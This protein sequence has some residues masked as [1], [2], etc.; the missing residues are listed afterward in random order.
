MKL[1][2]FLLIPVI[3]CAAPTSSIGSTVQL[4]EGLIQGSPRDANGILAFKGIPYAQPPVGNLRWRSPSPA[5]PWQGVINATQFGYTC[6][7]SVPNDTVFTPENENC[8]TLNIWTGAMSTTE[9]R[10][11]MVWIYGGGFQFGGTATPVY[12]GEN[13]AKLGVVLVTVNYRT[14]VFGFLAH[15]ELD[16]EGSFS[17]NFGLQDQLF[18]LKWV[19]A[20]IAAFGG[21]PQDITF[22]GES[23]GAMSMG[24]LM[25]SPKAQGLFQKTILESGA[26]WDSEHGNLPNFIEARERGLAYQLSFGATGIDA[27]RALP[28]ADVD[29][30]AYWNSSTDPSVT[31]FGP[32]IDYNVLVDIPARIFDQGRQ[33]Q[34]PMLAGFNSDEEL[35]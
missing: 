11:V 12:N 17:G 27:L 31:A 13:F 3:V 21:D 19:R 10:P 24:L 30:H 34:I 7:S 25:T 4:Q 18:A 26:Y 23:A 32:S 5:T 15:P 33:M 29:S 9:K 1:I 16:L 35:L 6:W 2:H 14:G 28:A 22:F 8:L 20:N